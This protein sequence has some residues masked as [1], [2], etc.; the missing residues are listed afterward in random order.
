[1]DATQPQF[2]LASAS[3]ARRS[4]LQN[5]GIEPIVSIS[6]FNEDLIHSDDPAKLVQMLAKGKAA[7]VVPRFSH[8]NALVLGCDSVLAI[9]GRIHGKPDNAEVAIARWQQ[10]RGNVG[11][12]YTGHSLIDIQHDRTVTKY[13]LT[14]VHFSDATDVEI[15]S[16]IGTGEPLNCAGCFTLE[17]MGGLL[18]N[19][20]EGCHTN[21]I[22]LSL[23]LLRQMIISLGYTITFTAQRTNIIPT[24]N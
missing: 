18:V 22:G 21:V 1:M 23:P 5:A 2:I 13:G 24:L 15:N 20:I 11:Q 8:H 6:N 17:G 16:Y 4:I 12:L 9:N 10:M 14:L 7:A 3:T 19:K